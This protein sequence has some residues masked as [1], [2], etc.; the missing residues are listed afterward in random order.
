[1]MPT[2]SVWALRLALVHL[3]VGLSVGAL[4]LAH[5]GVA[6]LPAGDWLAVHFHTMLFGWTIQLVIG[7]GYWILP[8][9]R[10][11]SSRGNDTLAIASVML[12]NVGTVVG[13]VLGL[14]GAAATVAWAMQAAAAACFAAHIWPRV[15]AF[16]AG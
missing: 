5:K 14:Y 6:F 11:G 4:M 7:V 1:M 10:G 3:G 16:G 13:A 2:L 8:K 9:F 15:K 12:V